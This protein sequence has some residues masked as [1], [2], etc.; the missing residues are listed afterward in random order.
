[1]ASVSTDVSSASSPEGGWPSAAPQPDSQEVK[2]GNPGDEEPDFVRGKD[3]AVSLLLDD[4][5]RAHPWTVCLADNTEESCH[6]NATHD[7]PGKE[8]PCSIRTAPRSSPISRALQGRGPCGHP[9]PLLASGYRMSL[10]RLVGAASR[11]TAKGSVMLGV[12]PDNLLMDGAASPRPDR[13]V[14]ETGALFHDHLIGLVTLHSSPDRWLAAVPEHPC[15][16][17]RGRARGR[18]C[19]AAVGRDR[20]AP[21]GAAGDRLRRHS[22]RAHR[23]PAVEWDDIIRASLESRF[24]AR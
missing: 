1:M 18:R 20:P 21:S 16:A 24:A 9:V 2:I 11:I 10:A 4:V 12:V 8:A 22:P 13:A 5:D 14:R 19:R 23:R 3:A 7:V 6:L 15:Q 17:L